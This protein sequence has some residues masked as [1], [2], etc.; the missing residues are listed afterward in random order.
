LTGRFR[1]T[2]ERVARIQRVARV[3]PRTTLA[4][5]AIHGVAGRARG[6]AAA[7]V[8]SAVGASRATRV[9]TRDGAVRGAA[10]SR[11]S[12]VA[13]RVPRTAVAIATVDGGAG[14]ARSPAAIAVGAAVA[15]GR[16]TGVLACDGEVRGTA[17]Q[18]VER[19]A[20]VVCGTAVSVATV[21]GGAAA[22]RSP[23]SRW[24]RRL[25]LIDRR[26]LERRCRDRDDTCDRKHRR[27]Q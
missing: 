3:G 25:S 27:G 21:H 4:V 16:A 2:A 22:A 5:A 23:A 17:D 11:I 8:R 12:R 6:L 18:G 15:A 14:R 13:R 19:I 20:R 1:R 9:G 26:Q 7:P 24:R 10:E